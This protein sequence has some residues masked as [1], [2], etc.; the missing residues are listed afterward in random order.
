MS[1]PR[2]KLMAAGAE[3]AHNNAPELRTAPFCASLYGICA[4]DGTTEFVR[5]AN[6]RIRGKRSLQ[7]HA[8]RDVACGPA[9]VY[10]KNVRPRRVTVATGD[11]FFLRKHARKHKLHPKVTESYDIQE[12]DARTYVIDQD[13][14]LYRVSGDHVVP[15]GPVD[16]EKLLERPYVAVPGAL[17]PGGSEVVF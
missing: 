12:T 1:H 4:S 13:G 15:A 8:R 3:T 2:N 9:A 16:L 7:V 17:Q 10:G 5:G 6:A 14:L 11:C